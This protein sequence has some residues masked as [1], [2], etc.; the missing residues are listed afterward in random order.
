MPLRMWTNDDWENRQKLRA[1]F[2]NHYAHIRDIVPKNNLLEWVPQDGYEPIC[3][4]LGVPVPN[5][6]FP[7]IN[8]GDNAAKIHKTLENI[9]APVVLWP[10]V[11][12]PIFTGFVLLVA[13]YFASKTI[14]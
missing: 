7:N 14:M 5:E 8:S 1:T 2:I 11:N 4:F 9:R 3:K 10:Y 6:P 12:L 13:W